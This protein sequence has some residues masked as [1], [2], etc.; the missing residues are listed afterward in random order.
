MDTERLLYRGYKIQITRTL[1][2]WRAAIFQDSELPEV[3][4]TKDPI[5]AADVQIA[6]I[7]AQQRIDAVLDKVRKA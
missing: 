4:W 1:V 7:Q 2:M 3:D 5:I 6:E